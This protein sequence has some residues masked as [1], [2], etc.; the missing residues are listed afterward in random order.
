MSTRLLAVAL[1]LVS[2]VA[3]AWFA[4]AARQAHDT[5]AASAIVAA[6][7]PPTAAQTAHAF[8]LLRTAKQLNPDTQVDV[9]RAQLL[10]DQGRRQA[11]RSVLQRVVASEPD[12]ALA[13]E[14]LARA[15][16][17]DT[18]EFFRAVLRFEQLVPAVHRQ[19]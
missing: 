1:A 19:R 8:S 12:N 2:L 16:V 15:S 9:L 6:G 18:A 5:A 11:A 14:W 10:L 13:W 4:L 3:A 7:S 17:G